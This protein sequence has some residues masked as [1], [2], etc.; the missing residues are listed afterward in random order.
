M[1]EFDYVYTRVG[2]PDGS[3]VTWRDEDGAIV[4]DLICDEYDSWREVERRFAYY[5]N[6]RSVLGG[7]NIGVRDEITDGFDAEIVEGPGMRGHSA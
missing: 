1:S 4:L 2:A 3:T 7:E 6:D 5:L